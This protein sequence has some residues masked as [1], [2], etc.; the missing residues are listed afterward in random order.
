M[1]E[2][3]AFRD[4][5]DL[6]GWKIQGE[7]GR[8]ASAPVPRRQA[9]SLR[10]RERRPDGKQLNEKIRHQRR[11]PKT[12]FAHTAQKSAVLTSSRSTAWLD[13]ITQCQSAQWRKPNV[14]PNS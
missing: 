11:S 14:W 13:V 1:V 9:E 5:G 6:N 10:H 3:P 2:R 8:K 4:F 7:S 12:V